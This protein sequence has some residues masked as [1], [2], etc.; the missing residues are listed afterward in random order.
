MKKISILE[1]VTGLGMGGAEKVVYDLSRTLNKNDYDLYVIGLSKRDEL[2][3]SFVKSGIKTEILYKDNSLKDFFSMLFFFN[4][5]IKTHKV[6]IIHA[7]MVHSL[8]VSSI[9][10]IFHPKLKIIFTSHNVVIGSKYMELLIYLLKPLRNMD[11]VF[12]KEIIK[13]FYKSNYKLI[14]NG[15]D[16][17][18]F[19][20]H[21]E[22]ESEFT[23]ISVG[24]LE[25]V[26][27]HKFII[28]IA[29]QLVG[30][31]N[32]QIQIVGNG[33][34]FNDLNNLIQKYN[35]KN[36]V[37]LLGTRDDIPELLS[38]AH[39]LI[40]PSL[41]EGLPIAIL[42]AGASQIPIVATNV[43]SIPSLLNTQNS[44]VCD[45]KDFQANM[46]QVLENYEMAKNKSQILYEKISQFYSLES[47]V[48]QHDEIYKSFV[49]DLERFR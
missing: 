47:V 1:L 35:L 46:I 31:Y 15:I 4:R 34:L 25:D 30:E 44:Y 32:F 12:S 40:M 42:E 5:F 6:D 37:K 7:H 16:L 41:W 48:K 23:F 22:K 2:L 8:I 38:K 19:Y 26:K 11:I 24:R 10:K 28:E 20:P 3:E 39:C 14:P 13:Y 36:V 9:L 17:K 18:K 21:G 27:N 29:K 45:I 33:Y 43:G 49:N